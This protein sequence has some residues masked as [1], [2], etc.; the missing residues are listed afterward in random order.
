MKNW[1]AE[2]EDEGQYVKD[3][4]LLHCK[5]VGINWGRDLSPSYPWHRI[6]HMLRASFLL[7]AEE[8]M[9]INTR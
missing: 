7:F 6:T 3:I 8:A 9:M 1:A 5:V 4:A 2:I